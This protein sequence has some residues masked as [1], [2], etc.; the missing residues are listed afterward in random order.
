MRARLSVLLFLQFAIPGAWV[1]ISSLWLEHE[2][3]FA[4][5]VTGIV[6]ATQA[7]G[8]ILAPL[9]A[10]QIADRWI[11]PERCIT[12]C[13]LIASV[14][15]WTLAELDTPV[16]VFCTS[17]GVWLV[18][19][20]AITLGTTYSLANLAH[21]ERDF[22]PVRLWGTVGWVVP[23]WLMGYWLA[24]AAWLSEL[25]GWLRPHDPGGR[26]GDAPRVA[27]L[28]AAA[29]GL[30]TLTLP[31]SARPVP[32]RSWLAPLA[33]IRLLRFRSFAVSCAGN[34]GVALTMAYA[35]QNVPLLLR[36]AGIA[37]EWLPPTQTLSQCLEAANLALL[38][39][40]LLRLEVRGTMALGLVLWTLGLSAWALGQPL[41]L[42]VA[43]LS[44][45]GIVVCCYFVTAALFV[46]RLATGDIRASAQGLLT[47]IN[48]LGML[49]GSLLGGW[50]RQW[51]GTDFPIVF[52]VAAAISAGFTI[53]FLVAFRG[54]ETATA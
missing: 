13:C 40:L 2:L 7:L 9:V 54:D 45:W 20:P 49:A 34:F 25:Y 10:G 23:M 3:K 36:H 26:F 47:F 24:N 32:A 21:P 46:N 17:L 8:A 12:A 44:T 15:L 43:A 35:G 39:M 50:M 52:A 16:A 18:L 27:S 51:T 19:S 6:V 53:L 30:Y 5:S 28:F 31:R 38:P 14:L 1:P 42:V 4:P 37:R 11:A 22:G 33:A 29:A 41:W 48:G